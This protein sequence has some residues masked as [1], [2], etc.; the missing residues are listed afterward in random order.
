M[1]VPGG[2]PK[3]VFPPFTGDRASCAQC[4]SSNV[5]MRYIPHG[6]CVHGLRLEIIGC[7]N[8]PHMH[9]ECGNCGNMWDEA[10]RL[11]ETN[12]NPDRPAKAVVADRAGSIDDLRTLA[13]EAIE[14]AAELRA[15]LA[16]EAPGH[17]VGHNTARHCPHSIVGTLFTE[18]CANCC[19]T[20]QTLLLARATWANT[21]G[22]VELRATITSARLLVDNLRASKKLRGL[23]DLAELHRILNEGN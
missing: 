5:A 17:A 21:A 10:P 11:P 8:N 22:A 3:E 1:I 9:R 18:I 23:P 13:S 20:C 14:Y 19:P 12:P 4:M 15:A 6:T 2:L 16:A 7:T